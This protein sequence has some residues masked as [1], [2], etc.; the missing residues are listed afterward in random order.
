MKYAHVFHDEETSEFK[1]TDVIEHEILVGDATPITRIPY[2]TPNALRGEMKAQIENMLQKGFIRESKS[3]WSAPAILVQKRSP[4]GKPKFRFCVDFRTLNSVTKYDSYPLPVLEETTCF[5][6]SNI[7][8]CSTA[9]V[10]F[11]RSP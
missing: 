7:S 8:R 2:P 5:L 11:G 6:A 10:D 9:T 4:D 1:G 3:P